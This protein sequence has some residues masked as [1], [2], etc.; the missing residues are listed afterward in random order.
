M[1]ERRPSPSADWMSFA[2]FPRVH[3]SLT[4]SSLRCVGRP[5]DMR[6]GLSTPVHLL[7]DRRQFAPALPKM[8]VHGASPW[9][10]L[11][12]HGHENPFNH[13]YVFLPLFETSITGAHPK[14][15]QLLSTSKNGS[16]PLTPPS[17]RSRNI[18]LT[19]TS[20]CCNVTGTATAC[21]LFKSR[22]RGEV[23]S[24]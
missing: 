19:K 15:N 16:D 7:V 2:M 17:R 11:L 14:Q 8:K 24:S 22:D 3:L 10:L 5:P 12:C 23:V 6:R 18:S 4:A 13:R 20:W 21:H 1:A 9:S